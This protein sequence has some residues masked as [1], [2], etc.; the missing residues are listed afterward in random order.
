MAIG[1][2]RTIGSPVFLFYQIIH[3]VSLFFVMLGVSRVLLGMM[4]LTMN[5]T[6]IS[7]PPKDPVTPSTAPTALPPDL[8]RSHSPLFS[9]PQHSNP[10]VSR[11]A[12]PLHRL[13]K[14][15]EVVYQRLPLAEIADADD[16]VLAEVSVLS[17]STQLSNC[18]HVPLQSLFHAP[19]AIHLQRR[20]TTPDTKANAVAPLRC[21]GSIHRFYLQHFLAALLCTYPLAL[22]LQ[23]RKFVLDFVATIYALY[24]LFTDVMLTAVLGGGTLHWWGAWLLGLTTLYAGT[25]VICRRKE[26]QEVRLPSGNGSSHAG[27]SG[28]GGSS[29][30]V[31][32]KSI[33]VGA[34][35]SRRGED[36]RE[37]DEI[38]STFQES[39]S[40]AS[41]AA[42]VSSAVAGIF[43]DKTGGRSRVAG[44][45]TSPR[46]VGVDMS[47]LTDVQLKSKSV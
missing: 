13:P 4:E 19:V 10:L 39:F 17:F 33:S 15:G 12:V 36:A 5:N 31:A 29:A 27:G 25:Y 2:G 42:V 1:L 47:G 28:N 8:L 26:M 11:V 7:V 45:S 16:G 44:G 24:W 40:P 30:V 41:A 18:F 21:D 3:C 46:P 6:A 38:R 43:Q 22:L 35:D 32:T 23:R 9:G 14:L 37:M 34:A 20:D